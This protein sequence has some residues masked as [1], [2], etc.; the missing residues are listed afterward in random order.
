MA[1]RHR[2][3]RR[4]TSDERR[5]RKKGSVTLLN[6]AFVFETLRAPIL[7]PRGSEQRDCLAARSRGESQEAGRKR[8]RTRGWMLVCLGLAIASTT[9]GQEMISNWSAPPY[10]SPSQ[11]SGEEAR[12]GM[13]HT[14]AAAAVAGPMPFVALAP[15]RLMDTRGNG[16]TGAFG[17]PSLGING[18]RDVP[19]QSHPVCTGIPANAGA[20]SL[21]MT[22]TNTGSQPFGFLK[23]W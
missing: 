6:S 7:L 20:Y 13:R 18:Q 10:W 12:S 8:M 17:P 15:C 16:Q 9:L 11:V 19:I 2:I 5:G 3:D 14:L 21:N 23:V 4:K 1:S 22:V